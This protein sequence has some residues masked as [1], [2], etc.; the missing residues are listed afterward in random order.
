MTTDVIRVSAHGL[1]VRVL[2]WW[3]RVLRLGRRAPRRLRLCE[4]LPLGEHRFVAVV[5]FEA[6]RFLVGGT[7]SSMVLLSRLTDCRK[8]EE[9]LSSTAVSQNGPDEKC[10]TC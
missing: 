8:Q 5:E 7:P 9:S 6:E 3:E 10:E 4:S 1:R 2:E